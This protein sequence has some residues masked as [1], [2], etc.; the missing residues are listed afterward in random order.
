MITITTA[1]IMIACIGPIPF[2]DLIKTLLTYVNECL[3]QLEIYDL[4]AVKKMEYYVQML[5][6][7]V[8]K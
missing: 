3:S 6:K 2:L 5:R 1:A 7:E 8:V 4:W